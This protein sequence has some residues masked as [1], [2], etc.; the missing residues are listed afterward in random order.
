MERAK[1]E[2]EII[3]NDK[4]QIIIVF[5]GTS[6]VRVKDT[7]ENIALLSNLEVELEFANKSKQNKS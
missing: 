6:Y 7:M 2:I 4:G 5:G 1:I 3:K